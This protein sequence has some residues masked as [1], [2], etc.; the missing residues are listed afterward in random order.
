MGASLNALSSLKWRRRQYFSRYRHLFYAAD[1]EGLC[2]GHRPVDRP[3]MIM[4]IGPGTADCPFSYRIIWRSL[5][6]VILANLIWVRFAAIL[7]DLN[8]S[9]VIVSKLQELTR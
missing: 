1:Q 6:S 8:V 5:M 4:V 9:G 3:I 2:F 7:A